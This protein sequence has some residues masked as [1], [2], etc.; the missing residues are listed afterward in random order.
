[1]VNLFKTVQLLLLTILEWLQT[2]THQSFLPVEYRS[3]R[4]VNLKQYNYSDSLY[5]SDY[6]LSPNTAQMK[7]LILQSHS[8]AGIPLAS[9][10]LQ[11][12]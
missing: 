5:W 6:Q 12:T 8:R 3:V 11:N 7:T 10:T 1:M 4:L 2:V 9:S